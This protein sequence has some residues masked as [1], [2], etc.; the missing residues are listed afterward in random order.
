VW[1]APAIPVLFARRTSM[2]APRITTITPTPTVLIILARL[3][4][5]AKLATLAA[6]LLALTLTNAAVDITATPTPTAPTMLARLHALAKLATLAAALFALTLTNA[7]VDITAT[8]TPTVPTML[9]HLHAP[10]KLVGLAAVLLALTLTS[11][12]KIRTIVTAMLA[13]R[14]APIPRAPLRAPADQD[15]AGMGLFAQNS[16]SVLQ[17]RTT[18]TPR[19]ASVRT[20]SA[21]LRA[22]ASLATPRLSVLPRAH[23]AS[24]LMSA[25]MTWTTASLQTAFAPIFL[26]HSLAHVLRAIPATACFVSSS[27]NAQ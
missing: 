24:T 26:A 13:K 25:L 16:T 2:N 23:C 10:A 11:A 8:P 19:R 27:V 4:A 20:P 18:V 15:L 3:H 17:G 6:V 7:V 9:A 14:F 1:L 22:A 12:H 5:F 21:R